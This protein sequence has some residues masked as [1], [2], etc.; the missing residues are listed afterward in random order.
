MT[1]IDHLNAVSAAVAGARADAAVKA[2][3]ATARAVTRRRVRRRVKRRA[4]AARAPAVFVFV[5]IEAVP[6]ALR[7]RFREG[8]FVERQPQSQ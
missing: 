8:L 5:D 7:N 6:Q 1:T 4:A 2:T 3:A